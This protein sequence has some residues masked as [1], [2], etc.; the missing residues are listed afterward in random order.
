MEAS[1]NI[2]IK[3]FISLLFLI[4]IFYYV[5]LQTNHY[6]LKQTFTKFY[7]T[8]NRT[9]ILAIYIPL[10]NT[11]ISNGTNT[12][13]KYPII[14]NTTVK[15]SIMTTTT[16]TGLPTTIDPAELLVE[17]PPPASRLNIKDDNGTLA[18]FLFQ[19]RH[20][21]LANLQLYLVRKLAINLITINLF[22]DGNASKEMRE[23]TDKHQAELFSFPHEKHR[24]NAGPSE[25]N[26]NIVNWAISTRAKRYLSNGTAILILDG[27]V[28]PLSQFNSATLLNSHDIVCRKH[29]AVFARF[30]WIG[31]ICL[32]P[33]LYNSIDSFDV[34]PTA[35]QG[36]AYD[37]GGKTIEYLL[38]YEN[39]SFSWMKETILLNIDK[40][41]FWG[42]VNQ[43][44]QWIQQ[45]FGA[46]DKCGPEIFFSPFNNSNVVFYHMISGTSEWRFSHQSSRRQSIHDAI[47]QSPYGPKQQYV[48]SDVIGSVKKIQKMELIPFHGNLTCERICQG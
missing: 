45:N 15:Y 20:H 11:V 21:V 2:W 23:V 6:R 42:A 28:L 14:N 1:N 25:R 19:T 5:S 17:R 9:R 10:F 47:M 18:V 34:A 27:D 22:T 3:L 13:T 35:R 26:A 46:C 48:I 12:T 38:K 33:Q 32:S 39:A 44:I 41:L 24:P 29:P 8:L 43:D 37:S 36:R 7:E 30:C 31:F 16:T 4:L 40:D